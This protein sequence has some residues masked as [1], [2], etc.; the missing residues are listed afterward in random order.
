MTIKRVFSP[1]VAGAL[2]VLALIAALL[3]TRRE[4]AAYRRGA[5]WAGER[6]AI[7]QL[8]GRRL[9]DLALAAAAGDSV[10]L[11]NAGGRYRLIWL[12][13]P[14]RCPEC[15]D[16]VG[17]W[18][19]MARANGMAADLVLEGV[20]PGRAAELAARHRV[21]AR[22]LADRERR[23]YP[24]TRTHVDAV[25]LLADPDGFIVLASGERAGCGWA[26]EEAAI[27]VRGRVDAS[28]GGTR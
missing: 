15:L 27:A 10:H 8:V 18:E 11:R 25:K 7:G 17:A 4:A 20:P 2:V 23:T 16:D 1:E 12:L 21:R 3:A 9:P 26:F 28:P 24:V 13:D 6:A 5:A 22:V 14:V 19:R